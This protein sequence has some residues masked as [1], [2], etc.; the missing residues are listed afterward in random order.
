MRR[1]D[2]L[3][4]VAEWSSTSREFEYHFADFLDQFYL[5]RRPDGGGAAQAERP[6]KTALASLMLA[7][8]YRRPGRTA[9]S[10]HPRS[11]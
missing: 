8:A 9:L 5:E 11:R 10:A 2:S 6:D 4:E 1:P 7:S 3:A